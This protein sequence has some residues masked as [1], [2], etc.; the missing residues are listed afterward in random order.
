MQ[1]AGHVARTGERRDAA[2]FLYGNLRDRGRVV[3]I[4]VNGKIILKR[5]CNKARWVV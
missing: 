3:G 4:G 2:G 5:I 1:W